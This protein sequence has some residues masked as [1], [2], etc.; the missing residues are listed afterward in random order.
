MP[1]YRYG[2]VYTADAETYAFNFDFENQIL[3]GYYDDTKKGK[4]NKVAAGTMIFVLC[5]A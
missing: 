5:S 2:R 4:T 1:I 3:N